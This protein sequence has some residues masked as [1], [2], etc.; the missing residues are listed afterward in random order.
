VAL[1][2]FEHPLSPY[3]RKVKIVLYEKGIPFERIFVNPNLS[4]RDPAFQQFVMASPRRE[5][6][7]LIDG[8][9]RIFD[10]TIMLDYIEE[11]WP[12][13]PSMPD[14]PAERARV[15]ML[16]EMADTSYEAINWGLMELRVFKRAEGERAE[17]IVARAREQLVKL[18]RRLERELEGREWLNGA[19]F[20]RGDAALLPHV[21][22]SAFFGVP[23][24]EAFP[25]LRA[26]FER[27]STRASVVRDAQE[28]AESVRRDLASLPQLQ[29]QSGKLPFARQYRDHRLE[30]MMKT[31]GPDIVL[32]GLANGTIRFAEEYE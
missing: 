10:S 18:W 11:R 1:Q 23:L 5:V 15:R 22:G 31:G 26:W 8:D 7:C 6:P 25:K 30:W 9:L 17:G 12:T 20:G 28:M 21:S 16:E 2:F 4:S 3:A 24:S 19:R 32:A 13:P 27:A 29:S 14:T